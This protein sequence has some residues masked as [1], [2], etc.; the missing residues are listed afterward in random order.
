MEKYCVALGQ[1]SEA[2]GLEPA[3]WKQGY[4]AGNHASLGNRCFPW[5]VFTGTLV[6]LWNLW[7][8]KPQPQLSFIWISLDPSKYREEAKVAF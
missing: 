7:S 2:G 6:Q 3:A 4:A 8:G 1:K 5:C